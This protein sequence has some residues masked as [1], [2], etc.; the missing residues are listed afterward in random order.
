MN[1]L[2]PADLHLLLAL[3]PRP[4]HGYALA[5]R[6]DDESG[7]AIRLLPGNL[8]AML[9]RLVREGLVT[10]TDQRPADERDDRR[11]RYFAL[12]DG[13]R[14]RLRDEGRRMERAAA[15]VRSRLTEPAAT[16]SEGG[17]G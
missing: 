5:Q 13:G 16:G 1:P 2:K 12:T 10:E 17:L 7:G 3:A 8:Y 4:L 9:R 15:L 6:I 14:R 11:R